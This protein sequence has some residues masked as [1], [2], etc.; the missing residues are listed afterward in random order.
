MLTRL[1]SGASE[2]GMN[3]QALFYVGL[4][5]GLLLGAAVFGVLWLHADDQGARH[6]K[7]RWE[8]ENPDKE[9]DPQNMTP[10]DRHTFYSYYTI[11]TGPR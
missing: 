5:M 1:V 7:R 4:V 8:L 6:W 9:F 2:T 11:N 3:S 10:W